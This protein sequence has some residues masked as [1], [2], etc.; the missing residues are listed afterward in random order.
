MPDQP[1]CQVHNGC[2]VTSG[3][4]HAYHEL[5]RRW[6]TRERMSSWL[7]YWDAPHT[8]YVNERHKHAYFDVVLAGVRPHLPGADSVVL[9]WGCGE[10]LAAQRMAEIAGMLLLYDAAPSTRER[11]RQFNRAD[12]RIRILDDNELAHV[13]AE[14][15]DLVIVN[16]V[17]QYLDNQ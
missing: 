13:A 8:I 6:R 11:L 3:G 17:L 5:K 16:S 15:I 14:S 10:A 12:P 2:D 4:A 9:D 1:T 7:G